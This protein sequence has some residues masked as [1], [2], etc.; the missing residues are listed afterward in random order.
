MYVLNILLKVMA[1]EQPNYISIKTYF[2][3]NIMYL[4]VDIIIDLKIYLKTMDNCSI[5]PS[6][7][8]QTKK[9]LKRFLRKWV[10]K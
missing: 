4:K 7:S 10:Q 5:P 8:I 2:Q 9:F 6:N 1:F 3:I